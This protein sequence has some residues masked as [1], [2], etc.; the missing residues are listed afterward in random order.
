M[1]IPHI[2]IR[3]EGSDLVIGHFPVDGRAAPQD[4]DLP[5]AE[6]DAN[7]F[8]AAAA[9]VGGY[10]LTTLRQWVPT[11]F[12]QYGKL[13]DEDAGAGP[14]KFALVMQLIQQSVASS[15][16][17][18]VPGIDML[19]SQEAAHSQDAQRFLVNSWPAIRERLQGFDTPRNPA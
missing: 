1:R 10:L 12:E 9:R 5:L 6:L 15:T 14:G 16:A 3:I 18:H 13:I 19:L 7:G 4:I 11:A 17:V 8:N 2:E